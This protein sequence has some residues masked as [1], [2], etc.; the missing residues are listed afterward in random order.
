LNSFSAGIRARLRGL[1]TGYTILVPLQ[2][3]NPFNHTPITALLNQKFNNQEK[4]M[5]KLYGHGVSNYYNVA[6]L[7]M[8]E[9]GLDFEEVVVGGEKDA[10]YMRKS[11]AGKMPFLET[12][13]GFITETNVILEYIDDACEGPSFFPSDPFAK[14]KVRELMKHMELY[15]ELP[16]RRLYPVAFMGGSAT[17]QEKAEVKELLEKGFAS[18]NA[19]AVFDPYIAGKELTYADFYSQFTLALATRVTKAV[20]DWNTLNE[21]PKFKAV[22]GE[23]GERESTKKVMEGQ[24]AAMAARAGQ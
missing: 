15:V 18:V 9:K 21:M 7:A 22:L 16:A 12:D 6:K 10:E 8:L 20:F 5:L 17:D 19:L 24:M 4:K 2:L 13:Q 11:P 23:L 3:P 14:A 1:A